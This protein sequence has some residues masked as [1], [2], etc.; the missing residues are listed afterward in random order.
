VPCGRQAPL[1]GVE[2]VQPGQ[3]VAVEGLHADLKLAVVPEGHPVP[4]IEFLLINLRYVVEHDED[5]LGG[6]LDNRGEGTVPADVLTAESQAPALQ[7]P[8]APLRG[9]RAAG[10]HL[11]WI[12]VAAVGGV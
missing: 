5:P 2:H 1:V 12:H 3:R 10:Q 7:P 8:A 4:G 6:V 11:R 9:V